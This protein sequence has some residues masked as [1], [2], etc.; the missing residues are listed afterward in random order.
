MKHG[1]IVSREWIFSKRQPPAKMS[2]RKGILTLIVNIKICRGTTR[3]PKFCGQGYLHLSFIKGVSCPHYN[4]EADRRPTVH[5]F[6]MDFT[7]G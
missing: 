1:K 2:A 7:K 5:N 3:I 4:G 6:I